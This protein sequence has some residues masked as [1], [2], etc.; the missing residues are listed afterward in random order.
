MKSAPVVKETVVPAPVSIVWEAFTNKEKMKE[1]YFDIP[2]LVLEEG[3]E[4]SFW[5]G[6]EEKKYLHLCRIKE[7][8]KQRK[9]SYTWRYEGYAGDTLVTIEFFPEGENTRIKLTHEGIETFPADNPDLSRERF[10]EGWDY[11]IG[12][13]IKE[14]LKKR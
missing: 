6:P 13:G 9:I 1:W 12:T 8:Q 4:F 10:E 14:Y 2:D 5:G 3:A 11:I 7:I